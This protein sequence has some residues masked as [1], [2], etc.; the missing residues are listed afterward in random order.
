MIA[1]VRLRLCYRTEIGRISIIDYIDDTVEAGLY[2]VFLSPCL[3][4]GS[5]LY[6]LWV[7]FS[8]IPAH[9]QASFEEWGCKGTNFSRINN[10]TPMKVNDRT[11]I[12]GF[13]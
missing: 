10:G 2:G 13:M 6:P 12:R 5:V 8:S 11:F 3:L 7:T 9:C 4:T 1:S